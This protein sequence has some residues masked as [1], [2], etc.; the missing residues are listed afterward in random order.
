MFI[1]IPHIEKT[2]L[3]L[4]FDFC[5]FIQ[6]LTILQIQIQFC[7]RHRQGMTLGEA[8]S[9]RLS[10]WD[11]E[12]LT[13]STLAPPTTPDT[14]PLEAASWVPAAFASAVAAAAMAAAGTAWRRRAKLA[15]MGARELAR[16]R[17]KLAQIRYQVTTA[18]GRWL[19]PGEDLIDV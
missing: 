10:H 9:Q 5:L 19:G 15:K 16:A 8:L 1:S 6:I 12:V 11:R 3:I 2:N 13:L 4:T 14:N 18:K 7:K 17:A